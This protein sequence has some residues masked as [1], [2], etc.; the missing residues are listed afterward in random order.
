MVRGGTFVSGGRGGGLGKN[1]VRR[2]SLAGMR[3]Q[4]VIRKGGPAGARLVGG[5]N[6]PA[7]VGKYPAGKAK[8][9]NLGDKPGRRFERRMFCEGTGA[10]KKIG[11][12][13]NTRLISKN[14]ARG[15]DTQGGPRQRKR[16]EDVRT[17]KRPAL[18]ARVQIV[19][20]RNHISKGPPPG[21]T[22][23]QKGWWKSKGSASW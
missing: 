10:T 12:Y 9:E 1:F 14:H 23:L 21:E 7:C 11:R 16:L 17:S 13:W 15:P 2:A 18:A 19:N 5:R 22:Q 20:R 4:K 3:A 8:K 6:S